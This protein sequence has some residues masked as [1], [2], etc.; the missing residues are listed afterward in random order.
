MPVP[1]PTLAEGGKEKLD[2]FVHD[3]VTE[4]RVPAFYAGATN[5][6]E[7]IYFHCEGEKKFGESA[8]GQINEES[9]ASRLVPRP[10]ASIDD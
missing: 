9:S 8:Q 6:K 5:A 4:R 7:P 3:K 10:L 1:L 2:K